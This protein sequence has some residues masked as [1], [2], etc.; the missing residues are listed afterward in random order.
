MDRLIVDAIRRATV[1]CGIALGVVIVSHMVLHWHY[2]SELLSFVFEITVLALAFLFLIWQNYQIFKQKRSQYQAD[3]RQL[4]EQIAKR[5]LELT[6]ANQ[7]LHQQLLERRRM[8]QSLQQSETELRLMT[9][10]IPGMLAYVDAQQRYQFVN[11]RYADWFKTSRSDLIGK[12]VRDVL[13]EAA[14][15]QV[16]GYIH[17]ALQ[18]E[19]IRFEVEL[20]L[21]RHQHRYVRSSYT[22]RFNSQR[23]EGFYVLVEDITEHKQVEIELR[24]SQRQLAAAQRLA[25]IGNWDY[26]LESGEI[27]GSDEFFRIHGFATPSS[28]FCYADYLQQ[29]HPEDRD[30]LQQAIESA[31]ES[32]ISYQLELRI[33][34][35]HAIRHLELRGEAVRNQTGQVVHLFGTVQDI[36][37]RKHTE[38]ALQRLTARLERS[39]QELE[40]F[41]F[42]ASHD[43]KEPLRTV[44]NFSG[45]LRKQYE[46]LLDARGVDYI[47]RMQRAVK[48]M[49][50]MI[51]DLLSLSRVTTRAQPFMS[52]NLEQIIQQVLA[53]LELCIRETHAQIETASLPTLDADPGQMYQL[54]QNLI[55]NALKYGGESPHIRIYSRLLTDEAW[56]NPLDGDLPTPSKPDFPDTPAAIDPTQPTACQILVEDQGIGFEQKYAERIFR[57]FERLHHLHD[58]EGTGIGLAICRKIVE[59]HRGTI[60]AQSRPGQGSTFIVTLP[61]HQ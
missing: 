9:D 20:S 13:G 6:E 50:Q 32:G 52:V 41:A 54:M 5:T 61:L 45:L 26:D 55:S 57:I 36:T 11:Q 21:S 17:R 51:D 7:Q 35:D 2:Q 60:T 29:V 43:L 39:N 18:G 38:E 4:E 53:N 8:E 23:I 12:Q 31:I 34:P 27:V 44:H 19:S 10:T 58:H 49:Q 14:Y 25:R 47:E 59:R 3:K 15:S 42:I 56:I 24:R 48:R 40:Q 28:Q 16:K 1:P 22:P 30:H 33:L 37:E 46:A